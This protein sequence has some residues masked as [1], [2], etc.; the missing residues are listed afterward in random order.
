MI[1]KFMVLMLLAILSMHVEAVSIYSSMN[2]KR[3]VKM[4]PIS[5]VSAKI[6][7]W[8]ADTFLQGE[9]R[10]F[11]MAALAWHPQVLP[12]YNDTFFKE[13]AAAN[14]ENYP[15]GRPLVRKNFALAL[16]TRAQKNQTGADFI[17]DKL[18]K[19]NLRDQLEIMNEFFCIID[20]FH[21]GNLSNEPDHL[22]T[23]D[24]RYEKLTKEEI[25]ACIDL[26]LLCPLEKLDYSSIMYL[27]KNHK[28]LIESI[29]DTR[30]QKLIATFS[31][32]VSHRNHDPSLLQ[33]VLQSLQSM[34]QSRK[35]L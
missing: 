23:R 10:L 20:G 31:Y 8:L 30:F 13:L 15:N 25:I 24:H 6:E 29:D 7:F 3:L 33:E 19:L 35:A 2:A 21:I 16:F 26:L 1:K 34:E 9:D 5:D 11:M 32:L 4:G 12:T 18:S 28:D 14:P 27:A 22:L 17:K